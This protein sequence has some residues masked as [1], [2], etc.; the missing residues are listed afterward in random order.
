MFEK[1]CNH[2]ILFIGNVNHLYKTVIDKI[3][4]AYMYIS[5]VELSL[6]YCWY[7]FPG[8]LKFNTEINKKTERNT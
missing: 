4:H 6:I 5:D 1:K 7:T 2:M 3:S 8:K